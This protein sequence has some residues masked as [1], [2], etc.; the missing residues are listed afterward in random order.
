MEWARGPVGAEKWVRRSGA[1]TPR[2]P[3]GSNP[4]TDTT[5]PRGQEDQVS[6]GEI[7]R[8]SLAEI[9]VI[10]PQMLGEDRQKDR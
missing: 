2:A 4:A 10:G 1:L 8:V 5:G 9:R 3:Y 7:R 6:S